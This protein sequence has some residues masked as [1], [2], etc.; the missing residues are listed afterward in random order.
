MQRTIDRETDV[1]GESARPRHDTLEQIR[2]A[3]LQLIYERGYE[4]MGLRL[5]AARAGIGQSTLYGHYATK[6]D[7]LLDLICLHMEELLAALHR[8][9]P[10]EG[11]PLDRYLA[12]VRFHLI[13]HIRRRREVF[14]CYSELRS[15]EP[16]NYRRVTGLRKHYER[17]L[18]GIITQGVGAGVM[19]RV[20]PRV[21]TYAVLSMLSGITN[22]Y[23]ADGPLPEEEICRT[24]LELATAAVIDPL[25][26]A[27]GP[28]GGSAPG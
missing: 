28:R 10:D 25:G 13:Y 14:I 26:V 22:W 2:S 8:A 1:A 3:G 27:L 20:D 18:I 16:E 21:T 9:V 7:L 23:R 24:Y 15:L 12:F 5:L 6:Q 19:R 17:V 4:G 11:D